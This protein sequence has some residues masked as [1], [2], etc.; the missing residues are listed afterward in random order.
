MLSHLEKQLV[1]KGFT[2]RRMDTA[3]I[4]EEVKLHPVTL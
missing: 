2:L 3:E 1:S 4:N